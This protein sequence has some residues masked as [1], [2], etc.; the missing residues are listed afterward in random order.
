MSEIA[1]LERSLCKNYSR[2]G[3]GDMFYVKK[4]VICSEPKANLIFNGWIA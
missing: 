2:S 4:D 1:N 3:V